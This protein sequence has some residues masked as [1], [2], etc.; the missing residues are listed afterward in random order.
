MAP[1]RTFNSN[2]G[3]GRIHSTLWILGL[4]RRITSKIFNYFF[5][6]NQPKYFSKGA[7][8]VANCYFETFKALKLN[9]LFVEV[10]I[11]MQTSQVVFFSLLNRKF[12][13][14]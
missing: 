13:L 11:F 6:K 2:G 3:N 5:P 4:Q 1:Y 10:A 12:I 7:K 9:Y 14:L 8:K